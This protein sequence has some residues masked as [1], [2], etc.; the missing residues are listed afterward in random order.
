V[1]LFERCCVV[2]GPDF[3]RQLHVMF[4]ADLAASDAILL[5]ACHRGALDLRL[6]GCFAHVQAYGR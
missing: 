6:R 2:L 4:D 1:K 5:P 3:S